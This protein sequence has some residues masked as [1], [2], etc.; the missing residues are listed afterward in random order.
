MAQA[1]RPPRLDQQLEDLVEHVIACERLERV[2]DRL[3]HAHHA[4]HHCRLPDWPGPMPLFWTCS[5]GH[6]WRRELS[7]GWTTN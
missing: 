1:D 2:Q 7:G 6:G 3:D 4:V 5:C